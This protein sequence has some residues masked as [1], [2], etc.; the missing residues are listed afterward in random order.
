MH[1]QKG[2]RL[3]PKTVKTACMKFWKE[4]AFEVPSSLVES[5]EK[6]RATGAA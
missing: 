2:D 5:S 6:K 1:D 3:K 4:Y